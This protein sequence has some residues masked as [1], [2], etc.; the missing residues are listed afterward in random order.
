MSGDGGTATRMR[1]GSGN[2]DERRSEL[3]G[4]PAAG[5]EQKRS[6]RQKQLDMSNAQETL[7]SALHEQILWNDMKIH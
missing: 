5:K 6:E 2:E 3:G 1:S 7:D 4:G